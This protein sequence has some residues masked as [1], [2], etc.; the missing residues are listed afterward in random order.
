MS[1]FEGG[2]AGWG[3]ERGA[4]GELRVPLKTGCGQGFYWRA[5]GRHQGSDSMY[6]PRAGGK[7]KARVADLGE[8]NLQMDFKAMGLDEGPKGEV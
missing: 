5:K 6:E 3:V 4:R 8:N 1:R 7:L 2:G